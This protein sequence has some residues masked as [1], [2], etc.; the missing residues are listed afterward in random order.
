MIPPA[1]HHFAPNAWI[2]DPVGLY[3]RG[4]TWVLHD[5]R[6]PGTGDQAIGWGRA[7]SEDLLHWR[8]DGMVLPPGENG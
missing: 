2:N 7:V 6:S 4:A 8:D 1:F 5:Q 3:R